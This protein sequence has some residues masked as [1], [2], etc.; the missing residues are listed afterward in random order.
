MKTEKSLVM[1]HSL[2][3]QVVFHPFFHGMALEHLEIAAQCASE[4]TFEPEQV[5]FEEGEP[6]SEFYLIESGLIAVEARQPLN[7]AVVLQRLDAGDVVGWSWLFP[8]YVWHFRAR[9]LKP[10]TAIV[11]NGAH[12][13]AAAE[14]NHHFGYELMKRVSRVLIQRMQAARRQLL[15]QP[16]ESILDG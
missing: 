16:F 4:A 3:S 5:L 8:P 15:T 12:L 13:L 10:A 11:L 2:R 1:N 6:A 7:G 9:A 14:C